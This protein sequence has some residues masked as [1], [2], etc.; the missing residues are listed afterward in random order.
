MHMRAAM[1]GGVL[2]GVAGMITVVVMTGVI[3]VMPVHV[4]R[5]RCGSA[6]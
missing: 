2:I 1:A 3:M 4:G 6:P 5:S